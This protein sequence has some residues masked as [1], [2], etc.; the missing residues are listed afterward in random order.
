MRMRLSFCPC[1]ICTMA[2]ASSSES[3]GGPSIATSMQ[4]SIFDVD[5]RCR[6]RVRTLFMVLNDRSTLA[7]PSGHSRIMEDIRERLGNVPQRTFSASTRE[8]RTSVEDGGFSFWRR[9]RRWLRNTRNSSRT[10]SVRVRSFGWLLQMIRKC[11]L[12]A[13]IP[14]SGKRGSNTV[15]E[16]HIAMTSPEN[17]VLIFCKRRLMN[18]WMFF[19]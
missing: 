5:S 11:S 17:R 2:R 6:R 15:V 18:D 1:H 10:S 7:V 16:V 14:E 13:D 8:R 4:A 12:Q 19:L 9:M 3:F